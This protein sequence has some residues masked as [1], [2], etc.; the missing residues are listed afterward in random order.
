MNLTGR[1]LVSG[2]VDAPG[3][4]DEIVLML[5]ESQHIRAA[6][7]VPKQLSSKELSFLFGV[8]ETPHQDP[9]NGLF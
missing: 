1:S 2:F 4:R 5:T 9:R 3:R 6:H 7:L 8:Q